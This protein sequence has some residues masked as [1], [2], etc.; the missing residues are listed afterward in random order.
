[1][2]VVP[3]RN[4]PDLKPDRSDTHGVAMKLYIILSTTAAVEQTAS[5]ERLD[6]REANRGLKEFIL[7]LYNET[8][9]YKNRSTIKDLKGVVYEPEIVQQEEVYSSTKGYGSSVESTEE[10]TNQDGRISSSLNNKPTTA[11][12]STEAEDLDVNN[13][14]ILPPESLSLSKD[15]NTTQYVI[16]V[17]ILILILMVF[18]VFGIIY[19]KN[20]SKFWKWSPQD[21]TLDTELSELHEI[22]ICSHCG[23]L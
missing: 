6:S 14:T 15:F 3:I 4:F 21:N 5:S 9:V 11:P 12:L 18:V 10:S 19:Y 16:P 7:K 2:F 8:F 13:D 17:A 23:L 22:V 20:R 1:M